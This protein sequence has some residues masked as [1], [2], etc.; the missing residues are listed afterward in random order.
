MPELRQ[1]PVSGHWVIIAPERAKRPS[2][3]AAYQP[4]AR[5]VELCPF[6]PGH[7]RE[8]PPEV[9]ACRDSGE[10]DKPGWRVRVVPNKFPALTLDGE[11]PVAGSH[12]VIIETPDHHRSLADCTLRQIEEVLGC[13]RRRML[14]LSRDP[15]V[16]SVFIFKNHGAAAGATREHTH[17]QLIALPAVPKRIA[18]EVERCHQ[19]FRDD[20]QCAFCGVLAK[21]L[22]EGQRTVL[23]TEHFVLLSPYAPRFP[24]ETWLVP[25]QH[26]SHFE[27]AAHAGLAL[28]LRSA[29]GRMNEALASPPY[30]AY[31]HTAPVSDDSLPYY[32]WHMELIPKLTQVAGF[33]W[34]TGCHINPTPPEE[35]A[36]ILREVPEK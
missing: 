24:F 25:K 31:I 28:A 4:S 14:D 20:G 26:H 6:C 16:R 7:E 21:E 36:R 9:F 13:F 33:E 29:L 27:R 22:D 23:E 5:P 8:T 11:G 12:E 3:Y 35:A 32:H 10:P 2:D 17:S 18:E 1:D 34:G 15:R 19:H 30:N